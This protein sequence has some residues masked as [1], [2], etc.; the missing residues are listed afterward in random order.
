MKKF[1]LFLFSIFVSSSVYAAQITDCLYRVNVTN[2]KKREVHTIVNKVV[3]QL[4][5]VA[6]DKLVKKKLII[7]RTSIGQTNIRPQSKKDFTL[8]VLQYMNI[9]K[10]NKKV[11]VS[12]YY[13]YK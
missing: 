8:R 13:F 9:L 12:K 5:T 6:C 3:E 4:G 11:K 7:K 2:V 10:D 1:A